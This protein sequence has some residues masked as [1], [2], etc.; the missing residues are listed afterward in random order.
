MKNKSLAIFFVIFLIG[1][2]NSEKRSA[3][4]DWII[5]NI[6]EKNCEIAFPYAA[7][8]T[9][10]EEYYVDNIGKVYSYEIDL[11]SQKLKDE[12]LAYKFAIYDYPEFKF[13]DSPEII[14]EFLRG[15]SE[16]LLV[17]FNASKLS[18]KKININGFPGKELY[19]YMASQA[20]YFT[21][22]MYIING[23]QY[24]LTVIS[25]KNNL[26]NKSITKF[27]NSFKIINNK[28]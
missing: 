23:K 17:S 2:T 4:K 8:K 28:P 20:V 13:Y 11:N 27:F 3:E 21:T 18:D 22:R 26:A 16:N 19:Y 6:K 10:K 5:L 25:D 14:N 7:Y 12:N 9:H 15:T 1:C 24:S